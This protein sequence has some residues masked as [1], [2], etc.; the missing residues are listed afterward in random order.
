M[1]IPAAGTA[2]TIFAVPD[3]FLAPGEALIAY[4]QAVFLS[5]SQGPYLGSGAAWPVLDGNHDPFDGCPPIA[6]IYVDDDAPG[7]PGPGNPSVSD[8]LENGTEQRPFDSIQEAILWAFDWETVVVRDGIYSGRGN[9][10]ISLYGRPVTV[11]SENGPDSCSIARSTD[12]GFSCINREP[13]AATIEGFTIEGA[14][15]YGIRVQ[16][17]S[18]T[19]RNCRLIGCGEAGIYAEGS[20]SLVE[21]CVFE[22][23]VKDA[24]S[25]RLTRDMTVRN[26][27]FE[28]NSGSFGAGIRCLSGDCKVLSCT[29]VENTTSPRSSG[30]GVSG[31]QVVVTHSIFWGNGNQLAVTGGQ[32]IVERSAVRGGLQGLPAVS[33]GTLTWSPTNR[34]DDPLF[35]NSAA[36]NF[37][38]R[39]SSP[40]VDVGKRVPA[41]GEFDLDG[42]LR[43]QQRAIDYGAY[44]R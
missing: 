4:L 17:A 15:R 1:N 25:A 18:P 16:T 6:E 30:L 40:Y 23:N 21:R 12:D 20:G 11:R 22:G 33:R 31:G 13:A 26:C 7:D 5:Q 34:Q 35:V 14:N 3:G 19:I 43:L 9:Q 29:F 28:G 42:E 41:Q 10:S 32:L 24:L 37:R 38:L 8:P 36:G 27:L 39:P 44:E 2:S